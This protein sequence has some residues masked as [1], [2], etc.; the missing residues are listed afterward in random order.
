MSEPLEKTRIALLPL[1]E[2]SLSPCLK[3]SPALSGLS[4]PPILINAPP[5]VLIIVPLTLST[6]AVANSA[7]CEDSVLIIN[8]Q[9][10]VKGIRRVF[11]IKWCR[12][13][14]LYVTINYFNSFRLQAFYNF[15]K[16]CCVVLRF[17]DTSL[18]FPGQ[19]HS[20]CMLP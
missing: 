18:S 20:I 12:V 8:R 16:R 7:A 14:M 13:D 1:V 3:I 11:M 19:T 9:N 17:S 5:S 10:R 6:F 4:R 15:P 2:L